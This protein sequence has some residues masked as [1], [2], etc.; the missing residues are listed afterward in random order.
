MGGRSSPGQEGPL[1]DPPS[2]PQG[3]IAQW[4][5][6]WKRYYFVCL[7]TGMSQ[8]EI[9]TQAAPTPSTPTPTP[10]QETSPFAQPGEQQ[11]L[12]EEMGLTVSR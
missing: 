7:S 4:D 5:A 9:P 6:A 1:H 2:L 10:G 3:W 11:G 12:D 8:W